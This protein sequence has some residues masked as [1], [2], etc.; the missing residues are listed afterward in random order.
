MPTSPVATPS[1]WTGH[2]QVSGGRLAVRERGGGEPVILLHPGFVADGLAPLFAEPALGR[3]RLVAYHR[4][5]YGGSDRA[6][7]PVSLAGQAGDVLAV[8]EAR[9]IGRA[10]LV[11]HSFGANVGLEVALA[12]P[13]RVAT[14]AL[15][16]PLLG[17]A[18]APATAQLV[19]DTAAES[20]RRLGQGDAAG[21]IDG[22]LEAAFDPGYRE[23]LER[24]L[25]GAFDQAM[26]DADAP[27]GVEVPSLQAWPRGPDD[28]RRVVQPAPVVRG[29][30]GRW[31]GFRETQ[32]AVASWLPL[33]E[34]LVVPGATH[35]LQIANP[36]AVA[37]G[38]AGFLAR[39][40]L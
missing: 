33:G 22:W 25:P 19:L 5:G 36:G 28:V 23:L 26:A 3:H 16:E 20:Y 12:A 18:V 8:M 37:E 11:G 13:E 7:G 4:R 15:L 30:D 29:A 34:P 40:P 6:T 2:V 17:F 35:L 10:H 1:T 9:G 32:E 31:P 27:F 24:A 38:L 21:A 14:L 39:H